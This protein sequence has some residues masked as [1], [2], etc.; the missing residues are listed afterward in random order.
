MRFVSTAG[1]APPASLQE[2]LFAGPAPDGGLYVPEAL[3]AI[4]PPEGGS[5]GDTAFAVARSLFAGD[6]ADEVLEP[7]VRESLDFDIPLVALDDGI[8]SLELFHGPTHAF[9]DV[10]A[11]FMARLIL[12]FLDSEATVLVATSGDTGSAVARAFLGLDGIRVVVLFPRGK[13]STLQQRLFST[14]GE[15][16]SSLSVDGTFDDC[17]TLVKQ[18]F[19]DRD[20]QRLVSA[21]S[22]N[23]GRLLPQTFY[24]FHL[25]AQLDASAREDLEVCTPSGN[26]GNLTAGLMAKR[27]GVPVS[28]FIAATNVNDVV[29]EYLKTGAFEPRPSTETLSNAMDVGNPSNFARMLWLYD[30]NVDTMRRDVVGRAYT[31]EQTRETIR[32]VHARLG[33][34]LDPHSA[35]GYMGARESKAATRV[36]LATAHPAKFRE[37]VEPVIKDKVPLPP[38]IRE[39]TTRPEYV[40]EMAADYEA[41]KAFLT[42]TK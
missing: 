22:I 24:Y 29:P 42:S 35:I 11:R 21:N 27:M 5:L 19:A 37:T 36:F 30:G 8:H 26:F 13:V 15:N 6:I 12:Q 25:F 38:A 31:D 14:L 41:L 40:S 10:G 16:V 39:S 32:S 7:I 23:V 18:A 34:V 1:K 28:Q 17:Q 33:Y 4:T 9:K 2:A 3:P 20:L